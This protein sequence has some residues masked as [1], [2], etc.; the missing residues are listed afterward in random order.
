MNDNE[1]FCFRTAV[2]L[3]SEKFT[4]EFDDKLS[5]ELNPLPMKG[6]PMRISLKPNAIP[7]KVTGASSTSIQRRGRR[8]S[9][10]PNE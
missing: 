7:K 4:S 1:E 3:L 8:R 2:M 9:T 6:D 10:G 5:D